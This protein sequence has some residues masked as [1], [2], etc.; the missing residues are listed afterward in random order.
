MRCEARETKI[1][2]NEKEMSG[3]EVVQSLSAVAGQDVE[4]VVHL[5]FIEHGHLSGALRALHRVVHLISVH[6]RWRWVGSLIHR[7]FCFL[8]PPPLPVPLVLLLLVFVAQH[9]LSLDRTVHHEHCSVLCAVLL[10]PE[11]T[12]QPGHVIIV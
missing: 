8:S 7:C 1:K 10:M 9:L 6:P 12:Q 3:S 2:K 11:G 5:I 4:E